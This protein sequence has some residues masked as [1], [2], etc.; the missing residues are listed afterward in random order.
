MGLK[1]YLKFHEKLLNFFAQS[2]GYPEKERQ[3][4]KGRKRM[5]GRGRKESYLVKVAPTVI[6]KSLRAYALSE[7]AVLCQ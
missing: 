7:Q 2:C 4:K 1:K 3:K 5:E 6:S